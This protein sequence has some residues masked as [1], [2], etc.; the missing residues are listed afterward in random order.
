MYGLFRGE[1]SAFWGEMILRP[2][3]RFYISVRS[4]GNGIFANFRVQVVRILL[5]SLDFIVRESAGILLGD[6]IF[7]PAVIG[8]M[9]LLVSRGR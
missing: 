2:R 8:F 9:L 7:L 4:Q 1:I 5:R 3:C 6:S